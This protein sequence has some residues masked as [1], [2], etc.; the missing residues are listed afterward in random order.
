MS[1]TFTHIGMNNFIQN[2]RVLAI[3]KVGTVS[4]QRI[5]EHARKTKKYLECTWGRQ[6]KSVILLDD[7][8]VIISAIK[9]K[10]LVNRLNGYFPDKQIGDESRDEDDEDYD[11]EEKV[12]EEVIEN[13]DSQ[14]DSEDPLALG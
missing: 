10:T 1:C 12:T 11:E 9:S 8:T 3:L 2:E 7:G 5:I 6:F 14:P 13:E 4:S